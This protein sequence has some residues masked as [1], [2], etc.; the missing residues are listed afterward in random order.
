MHLRELYRLDVVMTPNVV[1]HRIYREADKLVAELH[2][3]YTDAAEERAADQIIVER[4]VL[5]ADSLYFE[6][7]AGS[8]NRGEM[9]LAR[10]IA[11]QAQ[12]ALEQATDGRGYALFRIGD[13]VTGRNIHAAMFDAA[14][15][16]RS[17]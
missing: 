2:N 3:E 14:R 10:F 16:C 5:S 11:A 6:L 12:P 13:A 1:L 8:I 4:G 17:L 15:L 9:D 7:K